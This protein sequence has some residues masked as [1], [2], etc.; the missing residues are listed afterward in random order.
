[1]QYTQLSMLE[2]IDGVKRLN[3]TEYTY[4]SHNL[5]FSSYELSITQQK[6]ISLACKKITPIYIEKRLS[7]NDMT[8]VLG[9]M[10]FSLIEIS[11]SEYKREYNMKTNNLYDYLEKEIN[12]LYNKTFNYFNEDNKLKKRRWVSSIDFDRPNGKIS[13][14]FNPDI[15]LDILVFKGKYI[16]LLF[17]LKKKDIRSPY[18]FRIYE[19]LKAVSYL[20]KYK[21]SVEEF[22]FLLDITDKYKDFGKLNDKVIKPNIIIINKYSDIEVTYETIRCGRQGVK[23]IEFFI[24]KQKDYKIKGDDSF[25]DKIPT[26]FNEL[27]SCLDKFNIELTSTMAEEMFNIAIEITKNKYPD[28]NPL[29]YIKQKIKVLNNYILNNDVKD[30]VAFLMSALQ[31]DY[32]SNPIKKEKIGFDNFE[33]RE[34]DY[35]A[36]EKRLLGWE[37]SISIEDVTK[38]R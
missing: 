2:E 36:L 5:I 10:Q 26:A 18:S 34:Y 28:T 7:P 19:I 21:L 22:K 27:Q 1:M 35:D 6:I 25:K 37:K 32:K 13:L 3:N 31:N 12:T 38:K 15:I 17:D 20:G 30:T 9:V 23:W 16:P 14:T 4:K 24:K 11:V 29:D 33:G 8:K